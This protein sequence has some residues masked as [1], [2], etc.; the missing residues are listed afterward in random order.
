MLMPRLLRA[1][2]T[3]SKGLHQ[4]GSRQSHSTASDGSDKGFLSNYLSLWKKYPVPIWAGLTVIG[5]VQYRRIRHAHDEAL[6]EA[7][8]S[9]RL[10]ADPSVKSWKVKAYNSL[11][12]EALS[13][14]VRPEKTRNLFG[15]EINLHQLLF[16]VWILEHSRVASLGAKAH[17]GKLLQTVWRK[18]QRG[19]VPRGHR[20]QF[21][22]CALPK[23]IKTRSQ[24]VGG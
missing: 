5:F 12:L 9:G 23:T 15:K 10:C 6:K 8:E 13:R 3:N 21:T 7:L 4:S 20:L 19:R 16:T 17:S 22:Q 14:S 1:L 18:P 2:Q 11:P 24:T